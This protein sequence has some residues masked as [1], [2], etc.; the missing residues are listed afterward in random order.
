MHQRA[1]IEVDAAA[2]AHNARVFRRAIPAGT[3]LGILVKANGY[4]HGML[5]AARAAVAGGA[6]QL[7]VV[8]LEE[9]L[10]LRE[11]GADHPHPGRL[12]DRSA[13]R[14][15]GAGGRPGAERVGR[16]LGAAA[17]R[18][19][20]VEP[21]PRGRTDAP[22]AR[23]GRHGDGPRGHRSRRTCRVSWPPSMRP[24]AST[25]RAS[26]RTSPTAPIRSARPSR[27]VP[28]RRPWPASRPRAGRSRRATCPRP[29]AC[30]WP[31]ARPTTWS[32]SA[33]GSTASS[34]WA[35][36]P[37]RPSPPWRPS[38]GRP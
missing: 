25:S 15:R 21:R 20:G 38:C 1:W 18:G 32:A 22:A 37:R 17:A 28:T 35:S 10:A 19:L 33:S 12:S 26:G 8:S 23:R 7:M 4:G 5:V 2:L 24:A 14:R 6:D 13:L 27:C 34:G 30:S 16:R 9:G 36:S 11:A 3:R 31:P 29:R